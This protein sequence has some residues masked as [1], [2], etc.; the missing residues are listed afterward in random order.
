LPVDD[1]LALIGIIHACQE[2][3]ERGLTGA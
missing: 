1:D 3:D 2:A